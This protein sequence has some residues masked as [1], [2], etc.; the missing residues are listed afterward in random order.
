MLVGRHGKRLNGN[1]TNLSSKRDAHW[2]EAGCK[3]N[4]WESRE[5]EFQLVRE[6]ADNVMQY[7]YNGHTDTP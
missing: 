7:D 6:P 4:C 1:Q 2:S 5:T 3:L